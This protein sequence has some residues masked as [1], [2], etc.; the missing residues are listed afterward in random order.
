M[1]GNQIAYA[2]YLENKR[3]N[4]STEGETS[5]SN[6]A[7]EAET[8]RHNVATERETWRHNTAQQTYWNQSI[9]NAQNSLAETIRH[10]QANEV[11]QR[12]GA[13]LSAGASK[14]A[15]DKSY[16]ANTQ[17]NL[18]NYSTNAKKNVIA[19]R[20]VRNQEKQTRNQ[21]AMGAGNL[22][23]NLIKTGVQ[24]YSLFGR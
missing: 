18:L 16:A 9:Q 17:G 7:R 4:V 10:N 22:L 19:S 23:G 5:R 6:R 20:Q 8:T 13:E 1:T 3:H 24:L 14:Y 21:A 2:N 11:N 15:S 12:Y